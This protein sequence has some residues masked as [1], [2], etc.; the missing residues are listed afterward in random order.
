MAVIVL[1]V[2]MGIPSYGEEPEIPVGIPA[3]EIDEPTFSPD[4]AAAGESTSPDL[5][6]HVP[7]LTVDE[8]SKALSW[9]DG[10]NSPFEVIPIPP[11]GE[12]PAGLEEALEKS[13][14]NPE[15]S[16]PLGDE[17]E[18]LDSGVE[19]G[20]VGESAVGAMLQIQVLDTILLATLVGLGLVR[21]TKR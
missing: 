12:E 15:E 1:A 11:G 18:P 7:G 5:L 4:E 13:E 10:G 21:L 8:I 17:L 19:S 2:V 14:A 20:I 16:E 3:V 6:P 9:Q